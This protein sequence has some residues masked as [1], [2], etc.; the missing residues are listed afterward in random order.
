MRT[1]SI[2]ITLLF[3]VLL[4]TMSVSVFA[5]FRDDQGSP[6]TASLRGSTVFLNS[7]DDAIAN[8]GNKILLMI[9]LFL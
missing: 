9:L 2:A 6:S 3:A 1:S 7:L 8:N 5:G 4:G